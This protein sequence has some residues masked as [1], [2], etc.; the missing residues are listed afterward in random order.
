L[1]FYDGLSRFGSDTRRGRARQ[2]RDWKLGD[3]IPPPRGA[4]KSCT[5]S[6]FTTRASLWLCAPSRNE[7][8]LIAVFSPD[9]ERGRR[10]GCYSRGH[11]S[12]NDPWLIG[13]FLNNELPWYGEH[14]WPEDPNHSLFDR[15]LTLPT[16]APGRLGIIPLPPRT[17]RG[18][19]CA[20]SRLGHAGRYVGGIG[21]ATYPFA[22]EPRR[23]THENMRGR[24]TLPT[25]IFR[26]APPACD[27][28]TPIT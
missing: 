2:P 28:T 17:V 18:H 19:R 16:G 9:Y 5:S 22:E 7:D 14:G 1:G 21:S 27:V 24:D 23:Q 25:G 26:F 15:Y 20:E 6:R 8:R 4:A 12:Q 11:A 13:Y 10:A 3:L